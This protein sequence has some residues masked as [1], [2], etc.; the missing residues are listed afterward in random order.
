MFKA[1]NNI[2]RIEG[3]FRSNPYLCQTMVELAK[4]HRKLTGR[5]ETA[6]VVEGWLPEELVEMIVDFYT[7][8]GRLGEME[9]EWKDDREEFDL[10]REV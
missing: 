1:T 8:D 10:K 5:L 7:N 4:K 6:K 9:K 2:Y 3:K